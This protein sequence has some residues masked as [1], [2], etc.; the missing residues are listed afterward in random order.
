MMFRREQN[1]ILPF[2]PSGSELLSTETHPQHALLHF[3]D[4]DGD[5]RNEVFGIF[6]SN[7]QLYLFVLKEHFGHLRLISVK[8]GTGYQVSYLGAVHIK[9]QKKLSIVVGW[10]VAAIWSKLSIY[11]W[12]NSGLKEEKLNNDFTFSKIEIEDMPG[13]NGLNGKGEIALWIH[14]TGEAYRVELYR[15][16][17]DKLIPAKD[18]EPF[19]FKKVAAYYKQKIKEHP[20]YLFYYP[21]LQDAEKK[22][23][24]AA[25]ETRA[26]YLFPAVS[27]EI[28][29]NKWG[30]IDARGKFILPPTYDQ[31][32]DFQNQGLAIV[33]L[34]DHDGVIDSN[35]YFIV[36]P[37]YDTITP[38]SEGR[39]TVIDHQGFKVIDERG[40][41]ITSK[42]Y[43][44]ISDYK[45]GR[46]IIADSNELGQYLYGYLNRRGKVILLPEFESASDFN[47][48]KAVVKMKDGTFALIDLTGKIINKYA[49]SFVGKEAGGLLPFQKTRDGKFGYIDE[50]G[51]IVIEPK[52]SGALPFMD[53]RAIV[54]VTDDYKV[55]YGLINRSGS[56]LIKP[57]YN[58][59]LNLGEGRFALG[60][61]IDPDKP[62]V[63]SKYALT[64]SEGHIITGFI[65]N[66][67]T[68]YQDGLSSAY[69]D[70]STFFMD[71]NGKRMEHLPMVSGSGMLV[72]DKTLI[73]GEI[74]YRLIY[75]DKKG[76]LVWMQ[77]TVIPVDGQNTVTEHKY[78]PNKD[79]LVY[80]PQINGMAAVNQ[81]LKA[82][83]GV[84]EIPSHT[85]LNSNYVGD[86]DVTF[87]KKNLLVIEIT[88]YD[89]PFGAAHGMTVK[90]HVHIDLKS[91]VVYQLKDMFKS[92]SNYVKIISDNIEN[93][94][95]SNKKYSYVFP[96]TY[97]GIQANQPF[98]ISKDG[99]NILFTPYEIAPYSAGFPAFTVPFDDLKA[100]LNK[101]GNF[102][103]AFH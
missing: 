11:D 76:K 1:W 67:I 82:L 56:Y 48:G 16:E 13:K 73:K 45:E 95:K 19:Y 17:G 87:Y 75:F 27:K 68:K 26:V 91:D 84:K 70:Q 37:K 58:N 52:F 64:D 34:N 77:N 38:F 30:Y 103:K 86:F 101:D 53:G 12:T 39:A 8:E 36:K 7:Q 99:L 9:N 21:Y 100:I 57:N 72:F 25:N 6:R 20:D 28:G 98:F 47:E 22:A 18:V 35:G 96:D 23:L 71:K 97:K 78:K 94:I 69:N 46:A 3:A 102:W 51:N 2:L 43:S 4:L 66:G 32:G 83:A 59:L 15:W 93:Q 61:A 60:K 79:Y 49:Y 65:Y 90:N 88:G 31:S 14:D 50:Q 89:Y 55:Y 74:D 10:Q 33:R 24:I 41:E 5:G 54:T 44:F 62:Y 81:T 85:Q 92:D 42:A 80:Y 63:G 40:K 29:G